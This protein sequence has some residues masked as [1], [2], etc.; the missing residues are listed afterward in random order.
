MRPVLVLA[1][2]EFRDGIRDRWILA[3]AAVL[4]GLALVLSFVGSAPAGT[5][6]APA[7]EVAIVSL[8]S[9][10]VFLVPLI[11]LLL[12]FDAIVGEAEKGTL[13]LLLAYPVARWQLV[14][15]K[16]L[17]QLAVL[18]VATIIGYG[19]AGLVL[20]ARAGLA[21]G[22]TL[23]AFLTLVLSSILLGAVFL[24]IGLALSAA[25]RAR[26]TAAGLTVGVWL[27]LLVLYDLVLLGA[28]V[29]DQGR[30]LGPETVGALLLA[31]PADAFRL[32]NMTAFES[33]REL[34]GM[35][36]L[37]DGVVLPPAA[38][39]GALLVWTA[40]ALGLAVLLTRRREP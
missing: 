26:A 35:A 17:G 21:G 1:G 30:W 4:A 34:S 39:V 32:L 40:A 15:G 38:L 20:V 33:V 3:I 8:A 13:L 36:G 24:A 2:R 29:L 14:L 37:A 31:N 11:A 25:V 18:A 22:A 12:A 23:G 28:L 6:G 9:L 5:V 10:S 27:V 7:L 19:L 16:F